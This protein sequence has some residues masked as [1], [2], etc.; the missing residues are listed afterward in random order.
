VFILVAGSYV[1]G[2]ELSWHSFSS[3][4]A[5]GFPPAGVDV[6]VL[7]LVGR[8]AWPG[9]IAAIVAAEIGVDLQHHVAVV[10]AAG[11]AAANA[12]EPVV[13]A[14]CVWLLCRGQRPDLGT[15]GGLA[16]FVGGAVLSGPLAGALIGA[17]VSWLET[18]G[19]WPGLC[20]QWWAGDGIAVLVVG[21]PVLLWSQRR[22]LVSAHWPELTLMVLA[23][24]GVSVVAFR[25]GESP[26]LL[27]LPI[28]G[29]A[30]F[31][32]GDLGAVLAG[33]AFAGVANYMTAAGYGGLAHP[34]L[35]SPA[36]LAVT[37]AY[38]AIVVLIGWLLGQEVAAHISAVRDRDGAQAQ[39]EIADARRAAAELGALLAGSATVDFVGEQ[40]SAAIRHRTDAAHV[41]INILAADGRRF[42]QLAGDGAAAQAASITAGWTI[43]SDAPGPRAARDRVP[44]YLPDREDPSSKFTAA[45]HLGQALGLRSA[46]AFPLLTGT[47]PLG[48]LAVWW[49]EPHQTTAAEREYL[50]GISEAASRAVE[51]VRLRQAERRER[52][53]IE[54]LATLTSLLAAALTPEEVG[55]VVAD[56]VRKAA[57]DADA[58]YLG[59]IGRDNPGFDSVSRTGT[60]DAIGEQSPWLTTSIQATMADAVRLGHPVFA[61]ASHGPSGQPP[62]SWAAWP[63]R[64]GP[65]PLG[66]IGMV[67]RNHPG[68]QPGQVRFITAVADLIAQALVRARVYAD[69]H[70]TAVLLQRAV[71]PTQTTALPGLDVGTC[72]QQAGVT[73]Q[74][75]GDW[76][77][78][79]ALP[80]GRAYLCVGDVVGHGLAAAQDM[81]QLRNAGRALAVAGSPPADIL[82]QL[83]YIT[84]WTTN[85]K[86]ATMAAVI[87]E[88]KIPRL[89]YALAGHPPILIRRASTGVVEILS[90]ATGPPLCVPRDDADPSYEQHEI[91][92]DL[93]DTMLLYT[94]GLIERRGEDAFEGIARLASRLEAWRPD[95]PLGRLCDEL[96]TSLASEPQFDDMCV[97][98]VSRQQPPAEHGNERAG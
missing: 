90:G 64:A 51:R 40:V 34:G 6:A 58:L 52:T 14:S 4:L 53:R 28:L 35:S 71:M 75:G 26:F 93:G 72:Y 55:A 77:D 82:R 89:T 83:V 66:A 87:V 84:D 1:A 81:I 86:F 56:Q 65:G 57:D 94:D 30:A 22:A 47:G 38:I 29:L 24:A 21:G 95:R 60:A 91:P 73:R 45:H 15:R 59:L 70:A 54:A 98:A 32:L 63:L 74:V 48:Y 27:F 12:V 68:F 61:R 33:T 69:D 37:Q 2:A 79:L 78:A 85:G 17:T 25:F 67:W 13:G 43:D 42:G 76:Y 44:V 18:G 39:R 41:V 46:A 7:L 97:L 23:V 10:A 36:S 19:W 50:I 92:F 3:G 96:V 8:R 31:R 88:Q 5:F 16:R 49:K 80:G 62:W 9:P 20:L 11:S